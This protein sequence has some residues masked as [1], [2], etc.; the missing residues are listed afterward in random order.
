MKLFE[1]CFFM[2]LVVFIIDKESIIPYYMFN[3][4]LYGQRII[5]LSSVLK[6]I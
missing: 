4:L 5:D 6:F 3:N 2:F 1:I